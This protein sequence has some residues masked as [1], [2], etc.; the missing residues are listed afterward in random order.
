ML[1]SAFAVRKSLPAGDLPISHLDDPCRCHVQVDAADSSARD[2]VSEDD[3][4]V[5]DPLELLRMN[6]EPLP[7]RNDLAL[8]PLDH[9]VVPT[10]GPALHRG[11][12]G[13]GFDVLG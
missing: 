11:A 10:V 8:E 1:A 4:P 3:Q 2:P 5:P 13:N 12:E 9:A 7:A 6:L